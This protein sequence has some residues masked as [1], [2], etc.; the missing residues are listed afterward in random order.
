M[1]ILGVESQSERV[2]ERLRRERKREKERESVKGERERDMHSSLPLL[3]DL[4]LRIGREEANEI[5]LIDRWMRD[6]C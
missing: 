5:D 2:S 6:M 4:A 3:L 1:T